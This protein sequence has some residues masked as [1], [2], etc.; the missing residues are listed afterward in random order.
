MSG[1]ERLIGMPYRYG[2]NGSDGTIDCIHLVYAVLAD[3]KIPVPKF[4]SSWYEMSRYGYLRDFLQ[5][6]D[7]VTGAPY[8]GDV[9]LFSGQQPMFGA[10]WQKG[11]IYINQASNVVSWCPLPNLGNHWRCRY[12]PTKKI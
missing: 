7:R 5:W 3:L 4:Q 10:V 8:D 11:A 6:G 12:S 1:S 9:L 2:A